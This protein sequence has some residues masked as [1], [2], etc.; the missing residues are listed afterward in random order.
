[1]KL[2]QIT[3]SE[4]PEKKMKAVFETDTGR[5]KTIHFGAKGMDDYTLTHSKEQRA[6]Y[7]QRH[8]RNEDHNR[9]DTAG[10][11]SARILWGA[12]TSKA[13]NIQAFKNRFNL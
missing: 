3:T 6:R 4:K 8:S 13:Q 1:M 7:L 11:L 12:Y 5:T 2:L 10:S 9:P